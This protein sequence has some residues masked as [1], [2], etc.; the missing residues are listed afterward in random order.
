MSSAR[1]EVGGRSA[2]DRGG[3]RHREDR[4]D[5]CSKSNPD[6]GRLRGFRDIAMMCNRQQMHSPSDLGRR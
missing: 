5:P 1:E 4:E 2:S 6:H 3:G